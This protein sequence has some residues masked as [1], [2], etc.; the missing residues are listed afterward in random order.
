MLWLWLWVLLGS[1]TAVRSLSRYTLWLGYKNWV[2][3]ALL[4]PTLVL[5]PVWYIVMGRNSAIVNDIVKQ[6]KSNGIDWELRN[7]LH[8]NLEEMY[9]G[10]KD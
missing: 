9:R 2:F 5:W 4:I 6:L 1:Q 3:W 7:E 10:Y 8:N